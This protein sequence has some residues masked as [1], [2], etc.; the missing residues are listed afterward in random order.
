[1]LSIISNAV[2][3]F[4]DGFFIIVSTAISVCGLSV[5]ANATR[6]LFSMARD[7][8]VPG[9]RLFATVSPRLHTPVAAVLATA[10]LGAALIFLTQVEAVLVAMTVVLI[11]LAYGICTASALVARLRGWPQTPAAFSLGKAGLVIN[12][13]AV[14]W[15][16]AMIVNLAWY[17]PTPD[18]AWY[19][20]LATLIF[21]LAVIIIGAIYYYGFQQR[22]RAAAA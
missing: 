21:V 14:L 22:K 12:V 3:T 9:S 8:Q 15:G 13:L 19:L 20:N 11:Y 18:A 5:Q 7:R 6:L 10:I 16:A 17:R 1:L 4:S 2:P